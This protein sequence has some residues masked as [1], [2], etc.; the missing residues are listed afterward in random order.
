[1]TDGPF[2]GSS[3]RPPRTP[4][5]PRTRQSPPEV[6]PTPTEIADRA[7]ELFRTVGRRGERAADYWRR[8]EDE[9]LERAARRI[10]R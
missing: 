8:A 2:F 9:L 6:F 5:V 7:Y 10:V 1:M 4:R 3:R